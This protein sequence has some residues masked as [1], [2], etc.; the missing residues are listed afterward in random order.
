[1]VGLRV[2]EGDAA[3]VAGGGG[4]LAGADAVVPTPS[5]PDRAGVA[6]GV[7]GP[8]KVR[9]TAIA[10]TTVSAIRTISATAR[11]STPSSLTHWR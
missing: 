1:M 8:K 10:A 7:P 9:S 11:P 2:G 5:G 4:L 3:L 6:L